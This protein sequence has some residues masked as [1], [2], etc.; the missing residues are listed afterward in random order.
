MLHFEVVK[1][2]TETSKRQNSPWLNRCFSLSIFFF[3]TLQRKM[4]S[5]HFYL[6][7][8]KKV[9]KPLHTSFPL[10]CSY[11]PKLMDRKLMF[12]SKCFHNHKANS[13]FCQDESVNLPLGRGFRHHYPHYLAQI[14][15][16]TQLSRRFRK[17]GFRYLKGHTACVTDH[18]FDQLSTPCCFYAQQT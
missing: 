5:K 12:L 4:F 2:F 14:Q 11:P 3:L 13:W 10:G 1:T 16:L 8:S 15:R 9:V 7:N 17:C 6:P 18:T